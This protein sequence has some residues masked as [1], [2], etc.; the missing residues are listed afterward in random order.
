MYIAVGTPR[1]LTSR[2]KSG[3]NHHTNAGNLGEA[4]INVSILAIK[5]CKSVFATITYNSLALWSIKPDIMLSSVVREQSTIEEDGENVDLIWNPDGT[6]LIVVTNLGFIHYYDV[7][8]QKAPML[9]YL[10]NQQ[11]PDSFKIP[12]MYLRFNM[13]LEIDSGTQCGVGLS[14]QVLLCTNK[15]PSLLSLLWTGDANIKGTRSLQDLKF[16]KDPTERN[17]CITSNHA[18]NCIIR[19]KSFWTY[20][21]GRKS[22][23]VQ[24]DAGSRFRE[25]R[26]GW[27]TCLFTRRIRSCDYTGVQ[28]GI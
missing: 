1:I 28:S 7:V 26:L 11:T 21:I 4:A 17:F 6:Q 24:K 2:I 23:F 3:L 19:S 18:D 5:R 20:F 27:N 14:D 9:E 25:S 16:Y 22:L 13:A 15:P 8:Y 12:G 10:L